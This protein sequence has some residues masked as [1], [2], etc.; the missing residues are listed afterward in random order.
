MWQR[1][2]RD[3]WRVPKMMSIGRRTSWVW[4]KGM[5]RVLGPGAHCISD[6]EALSEEAAPLLDC[7]WRANWRRCMLVKTRGSRGSQCRHKRNPFLSW[8]RLKPRAKDKHE[9]K[10]RSNGAQASSKW[11]TNQKGCVKSISREWTDWLRQD[12]PF[13]CIDSWKH[14]R[15]WKCLMG[16]QPHDIYGWLGLLKARISFGNKMLNSWP[17]VQWGRCSRRRSIR[18]CS[19]RRTKVSPV[20]SCQRRSM[21]E[22]SR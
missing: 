5:I 6:D 10:R 8:F 14:V 21:D 19:L 18:V 4:S 2:R 22:G 15:V 3:L 1:D 12:G 11:K 17:S 16:T 9:E 13:C 7:H 20:L